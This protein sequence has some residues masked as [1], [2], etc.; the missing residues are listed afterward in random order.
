MKVGSILAYEPTHSIATKG[1]I[2]HSAATTRE[3]VTAGLLPCVPDV[4][5]MGSAPSP[6]LSTCERD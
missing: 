1:A 4:S 3:G 6:R 2:R 5:D